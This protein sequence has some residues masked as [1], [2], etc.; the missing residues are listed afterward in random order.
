[1]ATSACSTREKSCDPL[2][3]FNP[4]QLLDTKDTTC[5]ELMITIM[6]S[7]YDFNQS[8]GQHHNESRHDIAL[9]VQHH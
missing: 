8:T 3:L 1:M 4:E 7:L 2:L 6:F 5:E 9:Q